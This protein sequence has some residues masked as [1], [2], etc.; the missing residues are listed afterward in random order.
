MAAR[1]APATSCANVAQG[2]LPALRTRRPIRSMR[3]AGADVW[4]RVLRVAERKPA[5]MNYLNRKLS[6]ERRLGRSQPV[7]RDSSGQCRVRIVAAAVIGK[8]ER[9]A[10]TAHAYSHGRQLPRS[11]SSCAA[12]NPSLSGFFFRRP[13]PNVDPNALAP[14]AMASM[15]A[16]PV[17]F[18]A[19]PSP[20]VRMNA[21][22]QSWFVNRSASN[23]PALADVVANDRCR[24]GTGTQAQGAY[25][26]KNGLRHGVHEGLHVYFRSQSN[27]WLAE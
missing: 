26:N 5:R 27:A 10:A 11:R 8:T 7:D 4:P 12:R 14:I 2:Q 15:L 23:V 13:L 22:P 16:P 6:R 24:G 19:P 18:V 3:Q 25:A 1:S 21:Q 17:T 9:V 20:I